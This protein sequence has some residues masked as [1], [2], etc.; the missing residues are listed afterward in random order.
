[1]DCFFCKADAGRVS[2]DA[3]AVLCATCVQKLVNPPDLKPV[4]EKLS[5]EAKAE[6]KA[7]KVAKRTEKLEKLKTATR[8]RGRGWHLKKLFEFEGEYFTMGKNITA[9][10]A[11]KIRKQLAKQ[12]ESDPFKVA[13]KKRGRK[14]KVAR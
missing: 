7:A 3:K 2:K 5:P 6:K 14:P 9:A 4:P 13:P 10:E 12:P 1:M 8:G 11:A